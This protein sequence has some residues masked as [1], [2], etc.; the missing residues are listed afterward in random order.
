M[1]FSPKCRT[2]FHTRHPIWN[3]PQWQIPSY[4]DVCY[5]CVEICKHIYVYVFIIIW[6][7]I[8]VYCY[9]CVYIYVSNLDISFQC[10]LK[11]LFYCS[12][13]LFHVASHSDISLVMSYMNIDV[14]KHTQIT[15]VKICISL[16]ISSLCCIFLSTYIW[17][18]FLLFSLKRI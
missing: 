5:Q 7:C 16:L 2:S 15:C 3:E 4:S 18:A 17:F 6:V 9:L 1:K 13:L 12:P 10:Y 14:Y 11:G 8:Y